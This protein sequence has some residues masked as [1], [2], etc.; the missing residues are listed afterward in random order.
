MLECRQLGLRSQGPK[1]RES[2]SLSIRTKRWLL[3][4]NLDKNLSRKQISGSIPQNIP[5][6]LW[7]SSP[8]G[9]GNG[10]RYHTVWVRIPR[11]PQCLILS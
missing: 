6:C 3:Q 11:G 10:L 5:S 7:P 8:T 9:R 1:G 2:S 4:A